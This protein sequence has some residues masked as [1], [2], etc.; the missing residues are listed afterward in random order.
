M[1]A[2]EAVPMVPALD[3]VDYWSPEE[4]GAFDQFL[5]RNG[6]SKV[7]FDQIPKPHLE[8]VK[9]L[10]TAYIYPRRGAAVAVPPVVA[11]EREILRL[12][13]YSHVCTHGGNGTWIRFSSLLMQNRR[14]AM[15]D[16]VAETMHDNGR[17]HLFL[18]ADGHTGYDAV[19]FI[20]KHLLTRL[21]TLADPHDEAALILAF[22]KLDVDFFDEFMATEKAEAGG[23]FKSSGAAVTL[24][25]LSPSGD[26][27]GTTRLTLAHVGDTCAIVY[28]PR[29]AAEASES[30]DAQ[31]SAAAA[32]AAAPALFQKL[33][34]DHRPSNPV[35]RARIEKAGYHV[36]DDRVNG[37]LAFSRS[38]G[39][40]EYKVQLCQGADKKQFTVYDPDGAVIATPMVRHCILNPGER[41]LLLTDGFWEGFDL[42]KFESA[43][44]ILDSP[45]LDLHLLLW[46][47]TIA[48]IGQGS[49]DNHGIIAIEMGDSGAREPQHKTFAT[50]WDCPI[51]VAASAAWR[52]CYLQWKER[53]SNPILL[54]VK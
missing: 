54:G 1:A 21:K 2:A 3:P 52:R 27:T 50:A 36:T 42:A 9:S 51:P 20:D 13:I 35:E 29:P 8:M 22:K 16:F 10:W 14:M 28:R 43:A 18:V 39:D 34:E 25:V 4:A 40:I 24:A 44:R 41:V 11:D 23:S 19:Q 48:S 33:T 47:L 46:K 12:P 30:K 7:A 31:P 17:T 15:E 5:V 37:G 32:P 38:V 49:F 45:N 6:I 53:Y 26:G